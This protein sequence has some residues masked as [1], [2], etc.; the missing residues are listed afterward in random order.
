MQFKAG[1]IIQRPLTDSFGHVYKHIGIF[2]SEDE[3]IHFNGT[4][5]GDR[6]AVVK[7]ESLVDFAAGC[8]VTVKACPCDDDHAFAV[9]QEAQR[10]ITLEN[11]YD[12]K[13]SFVRKNCEDFAVHCYQIEFTT[14]SDPEKKRK[15]MAPPSQKKRTIWGMLGTA[16][17]AASAV[18]AIVI[19][20]RGNKRS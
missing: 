15:E 10:Q 12:R 1:S 17:S 8:D 5:K 3:V 7:S 6:D 4:Q 9:V 2:V 14:A 19:F 18:I 13:Y 20:G 11:D 16:V